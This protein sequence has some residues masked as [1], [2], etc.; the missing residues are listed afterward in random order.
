[1]NEEL[2]A[3]WLAGVTA[4]LMEFGES[5]AALQDASSVTLVRKVGRDLHTFKGEAR[6][7]GLQDI[8]QIAHAAEDILFA[9]QRSGHLGLE[10]QKCLYEALDGIFAVVQALQAHEPPPQLEETKQKLRQHAAEAM[11]EASAAPA[12]SQE[13]AEPE[14]QHAAGPEP[15]HAA[16]PTHITAPEHHTSRAADFT[17]IRASVLTHISDLTSLNAGATG[18]NRL[19]VDGLWRSAKT[20][21][22]AAEKTQAPEVRSMAAD[23][24]TQLRGLRERLGRDTSLAA[25]LRDVVHGALLKPLSSVA[26]GYPAF[27]RQTARTLGKN[28]EV[29]LRGMELLLEERVLQEV[30]EPLL[31]L[32]RNAIAHGI[33]APAERLAAGKPEAG[34][35]VL[36]A[37]QE[38]DTVRL[39]LTDDGRG[40]NSQRIGARAVELGIVTRERLA[41]MGDRERM[42]LAFSAGLSTASKTDEISGRGVGLDV[43]ASVIERIGGV[44]EL[45][46]NLGQGTQFILRVPVS[47]SLQRSMLV[48]SCDQKFAIPSTFVSEVFWLPTQ[49][50]RVQDGHESAL[51][52]GELMPLV[53]LRSALRLVGIKDIF[54]N[55]VVVVV[56]HL[57]EGRLGIVVDRCYGERELVMQAFGALTGRPRCTAGLA[58]LEDESVVVVL[59]PP[60]LM[61][62]RKGARTDLAGVAGRTAGKAKRVLYAEDS[63]ITREYT[64]GVLR[65]AGFTVTEVGDGVDALAAL[66]KESFDMLLTDLQMPR[67]DGFKLIGLIRRGEVARNIPIIIMSTVDSEDTKA[68]AL[69]SGADGYIVKAQFSADVILDAIAKVLG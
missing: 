30:A 65:A 25:E 42:L 19:A 58:L 53:R 62:A 66:R 24:L 7:F 49:Q 28:V 17:A 44:V 35:V 29:E 20:L 21:V 41:S 51:Y 4:R 3:K 18:R 6:L 33:E 2:L 69:Q 23:L 54:V 60:D 26:A 50:I 47:T 1:M 67:M 14:P 22:E 27:A 38:G 43:V 46:S 61:D 12:P 45:Q 57:A 40:L 10:T 39:T 56:V 48:E 11:K 52:R 32:L 36:A 31:H 55:K 9:H 5:V 16:E 15:A 68:M 37:V 8:E 63:V 13:T 64:A 34:R 59:Q